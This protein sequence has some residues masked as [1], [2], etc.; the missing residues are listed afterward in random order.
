M[1]RKPLMP[2]DRVRCRHVAGRC[3]GH[4][5]TAAHF[6]LPLAGGHGAIVAMYPD[7]CGYTAGATVPS[8]QFIRLPKRGARRG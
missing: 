6:Y 5:V 3:P 4:R 1:K 7:A 2:D 8:C